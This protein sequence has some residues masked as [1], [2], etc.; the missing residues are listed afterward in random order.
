[1]IPAEVIAAKRDNGILSDA[2][3]EFFV[4]GF[5]KEE[6]P[7]YQMSALAM[8]IFL[9]GMT[10]QETA[11]LTKQTVSYTHLTLPTICSV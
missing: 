4:Q 9:N 5:A 1:M 2:Q 11:S 10:T 8:A 3:I 6:I 7:D